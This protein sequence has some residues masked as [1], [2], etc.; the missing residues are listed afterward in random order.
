MLPWF[1]RFKK[2]QIQK[3]AIG[4]RIAAFIGPTQQMER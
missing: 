1:R 4:G 2:S 3:T